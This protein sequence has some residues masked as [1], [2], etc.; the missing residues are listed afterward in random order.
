MDKMIL[1]IGGHEIYLESA[2]VENNNAALILG[3]GHN[4][5]LDGCPDARLVTVTVYAPD[6]KKLTPTLN[7]KEEYHEIKFDCDRPGYYTTIV[8]LSPMVYSN[9]TKE[10]FK[11]GPKS[12]YKDVVYAG[13]WHQMAKTIIAAGVTGEY[14]P[15]HLHGIL[16]IIPTE[17]SLVNGKDIELTLLY[18][19]QLLAGS[20]IKA[21]SKDTGK[22]MALVVTDQ[23][24]IAKIPITCSGEWMFLSRHR[25]P[26]KAVEDKYDEAVFVTTLVMKTS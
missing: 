21:V 24:G 6:K 2:I 22:E 18:E 9:T 19:G 4:M 26:S 17:A 1:M 5:R 14:V 25:D 12:M 20:E 23:D 11:E 15:E 3:Y 7:T 10:G 8:D 13:A 16:D